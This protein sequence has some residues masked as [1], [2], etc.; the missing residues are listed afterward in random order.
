M[1]E[2]LSQQACPETAADHRGRDG[3]RELGCVV[4]DPAVAAVV[5]GEEPHPGG[6]DRPTRPFG[7]D[8]EIARLPEADDVA[9]EHRVGEELLGAYPLV[10][11]GVRRVE[12]HRE[13]KRLV[14]GTRVE[15]RE[16][17]STGAWCAAEPPASSLQS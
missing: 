3:D 5:A 14:V 9:G 10:L 17:C 15:A 12:E 13:E 6:A 8:S 7:D 11:V 4:G 2:E 16:S 1:V